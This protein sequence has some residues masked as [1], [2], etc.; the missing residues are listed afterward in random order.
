MSRIHS[1]KTRQKKGKVR[2]RL[3]E[4]HI[5]Q[6]DRREKNRLKRHRLKKSKSVYTYLN[7]SVSSKMA[8]GDS[9]ILDG[10]SIENLTLIDDS[11]RFDS[12][13]ISQMG[14]T[15]N[16][17][18]VMS[19]KT[20][21]LREARSQRKEDKQKKRRFEYNITVNDI[22]ISHLEF[23]KLFLKSGLTG[24]V[25]DKLDHCQRVLGYQ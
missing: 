4:P 5:S 21:D 3:L 6:L 7:Q 20:Y 2:V 13:S 24:Q 25:N 15:G 18:N 12:K 10:E 14:K 23:G 11:S 19:Q 16:K 9:F 22:K 1:S 8:F 17:G